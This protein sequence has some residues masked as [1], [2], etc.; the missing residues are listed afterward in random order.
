MEIILRMRHRVGNQGIL[1]IINYASV[2]VTSAKQRHK[3]NGKKKKKK[4]LPFQSLNQPHHETRHPTTVVFRTLMLPGIPGNAALPGGNR[5][6][7]LRRRR[8]CCLS[9][10]F[11]PW[12]GGRCVRGL[13]L[14]STTALPLLLLPLLLLGRFLFL[15][16]IIITSSGRGRW[17]WWR[18]VLVELPE[19]GPARQ[20]PVFFLRTRLPFQLMVIPSILREMNPPFTTARAGMHLQRT[21]VSETTSSSDRA[22]RLRT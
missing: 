7:S 20:V 16:A 11:I 1:K 4:T 3:K 13:L 18:C 9:R 22:D 19:P 5:E 6:V 12:N 21:R 10:F 2:M 15:W 17:W 14:L 8:C